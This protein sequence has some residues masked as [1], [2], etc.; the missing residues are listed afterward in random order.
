[1]MSREPHGGGVISLS[2]ITIF[3][4]STYCFFSLLLGLVLNWRFCRLNS[5]ENAGP[6]VYKSN[7]RNTECGFEV[8]FERRL[9][10]LLR[11]MVASG[12]VF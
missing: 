5:N 12:D 11:S 4:F 7:I 9:K 6:F 1:M 10:A 3:R 2:H 8:T